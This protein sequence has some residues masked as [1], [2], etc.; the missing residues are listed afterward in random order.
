[1]N[2]LLLSML[3][4]A[5]T[6]AEVVSLLNA[7]IQLYKILKELDEEREDEQEEVDISGISFVKGVDY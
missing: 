6:L 7:I 5:S 1:M 4:N 3:F 2:T